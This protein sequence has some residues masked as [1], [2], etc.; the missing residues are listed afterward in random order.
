MTTIVPCRARAPRA[1]PATA[2]PIRIG[3]LGCGLIGSA[4]A[5]LAHARPDALGR[6]TSIAAALVRRTAHRA[7]PVNIRL[8]AD[9]EAV[10]NAEPDVIVEVLGSLEPARSLVLRAFERG[11]PV[12]ADGLPQLVRAI[13]GRRPTWLDAGQAAQR[14]DHSH[15]PSV[16]LLSRS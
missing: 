10:F 11:I 7:A 3:L 8:T 5:A 9:A 6:P 4:V 13:G 15:R 14:A 2:A 12:G 1:A 16:L